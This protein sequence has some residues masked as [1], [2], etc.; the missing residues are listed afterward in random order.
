MFV[1]FADTKFVLQENFCNLQNHEKFF[2]NTPLPQ[3]GFHN[4]PK[5]AI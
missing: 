2:V 1:Y 5:K 3:E 4:L